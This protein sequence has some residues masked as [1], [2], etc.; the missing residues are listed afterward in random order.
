MKAI[1]SLLFLSLVLLAISQPATSALP[2]VI[3]GKL[4]LNWTNAPNGTQI[5][6]NTYV[7]TVYFMSNLVSSQND[8]VLL[9]IAINA[10]VEGVNYQ[11]NAP[12]Y[13]W[14]IISTTGLL[15]AAGE[16]KI[17][18][19][20]GPFLH[21][22]LLQLA[23]KPSAYRLEFEITGLWFRG[24]TKNGAVCTVN[25]KIYEAS[26]QTQ[27]KEPQQ[28]DKEINPATSRLKISL[29]MMIRVADH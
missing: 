26:L 3:Q 20:N 8:T 25:I 18:D 4:L 15:L 27:P 19:N 23:T 21:D 9:R 5:R 7:G 28:P 24:I 17:T 11:I 14:K 2:N 29:M 6:G 1:P 12:F 22:H 16:D 10:T 13:T